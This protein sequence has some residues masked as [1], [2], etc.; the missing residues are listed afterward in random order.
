MPGEL[1]ALL[2]TLILP[3]HSLRVRPI[4]AMAAARATRWRAP[5]FGAPPA[6]LY[7]S[8]ALNESIL[9]ILP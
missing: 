1:L 5:A 7:A 9:L 2:D 4:P 8:D 6:G 3:A